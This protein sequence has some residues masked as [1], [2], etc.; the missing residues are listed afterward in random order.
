MAEQLYTR[1]KIKRSFLGLRTERPRAEL[2]QA[3][4]LTGGGAPIVLM[5][6]ER[7]TSGEAAWGGY[8]TVY[9]VD[10]GKHSLQVTGSAPS[11]DGI[12]EFRFNLSVSY[13]VNNPRQVI[14]DRLEN[15]RDPLQ[16]VLTETIRRVTAR[17][18][19][20]EVQQAAAEARTLLEKNQLSSKLPFELSD[21]SLRLEVDEARKSIAQTLNKHEREVLEEKHRQE[22]F[23]IRREMYESMA[24]GGQMAAMIQQLAQRPDDIAQ[25]AD[26]LRQ[27][28]EQRRLE[29]LQL[30][31]AMLDKDMVQDH[32]MKDVI[33]NIV[34][35]VSRA[36]GGGRDR[37]P[38]SQPRRLPPAAETGEEDEQ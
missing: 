14:E 12:A 22:I 28:D 21:V 23:R 20:R 2:G 29:N 35:S 33:V 27:Q 16:Q 38:G 25:V 37:L 32:H 4:V 34:D 13:R 9:E 7:A 31:Q 8:D 1:R 11:A 18:D 10:M 36:T 17:Y 24:Q 6:G 3:L 5:P 19:I 26:I 30:L 15:P